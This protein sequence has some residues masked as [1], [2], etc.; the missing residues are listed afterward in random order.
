MFRVTGEDTLHNKYSMIWNQFTNYFMALSSYIHNFSPLQLLN[1]IFKIQMQSI[2]GELLYIIWMFCTLPVTVA[3]GERAF[4]KARRIKDY[5][6]STMCQ[7]R[8]NHPVYSMQRW[9]PENCI[10]VT[11]LITL[12][13]WRL[14]RGLYKLWKGDGGDL[15]A[16]PMFVLYQ[17]LNL[18]VILD[19]LIII[20]SLRTD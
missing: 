18:R 10:P 16:M 13:A 12:L 20:L 15:L 3:A 8:V 11:L 14:S 6:S 2:F 19:N 7:D 17:I 4:H 9:M 1:A 5:L